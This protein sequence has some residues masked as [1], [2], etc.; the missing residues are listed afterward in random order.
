ML[1]SFTPL[2]FLFRIV[3]DINYTDC[4]CCFDFFKL[5]LSRNKTNDLKQGSQL[6]LP[7]GYICY[8]RTVQGPEIL[9]NKILSGS[10][11]ILPN[12]QIFCKYIIFQL[13]TKCLHRPDEMVSWARFGLQAVV[14]R[15]L[16]ESKA[17]RTVEVGQHKSH[18]I[19][20]SKHSCK[21]CV[22]NMWTAILWGIAQSN[23]LQFT[24]CFECM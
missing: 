19:H 14:W 22:S 16:V 18:S 1:L 24:V 4:P 2:M 8:S 12:Q 23:F 13:L 6:F 20:C 15:P 10:C 3:C 9:N 5:D 17:F 7:D 21:F 11:Y